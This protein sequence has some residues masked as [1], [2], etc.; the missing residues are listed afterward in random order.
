MRTKI[1]RQKFGDPAW[2]LIAKTSY[3]FLQDSL[4]LDHTS[5]VS[6]RLTGTG[7]YDLSYDYRKLITKSDLTQDILTLLKV[8]LTTYR[9][10]LSYLR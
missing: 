2:G 6:S 1:R 8:C 4:K 7:P 3:D 9:K 5:I 10:S